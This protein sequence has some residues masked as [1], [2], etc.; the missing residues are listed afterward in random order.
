MTQDVE[1]FDCRLRF[2]QVDETVIL[3]LQSLWPVIENDLDGILTDFYDHLLQYSELATMIGEQQGSL[4]TAQKAHWE[5][6]FLQGFD[7]DYVASINRI[8]RV[9][10][11][12]G[13]EPRW[14]IAGYKFVLVRLQE[15]IVRKFRFSPGKLSRALSHVTTAVLLDL[16]MAISTYQAILMEAQ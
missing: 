15:L 13:L 2:A 4:E 9:H 1:V 16:D 11:R 8:G 5:K 6:L 10:S 14:Y 12:I 7:D 3:G